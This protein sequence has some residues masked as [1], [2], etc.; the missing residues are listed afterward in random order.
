MTKARKKW[1][2]Q[3]QY[4]ERL[5]IDPA[6]SA[7]QLH[8]KDFN[9]GISFLYTANLQKELSLNRFRLYNQPASFKL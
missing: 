9:S 4:V 5:T 6:K 7:Q 3:I 2:K 8:R 1:P